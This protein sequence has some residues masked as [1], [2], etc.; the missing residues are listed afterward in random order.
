MKTTHRKLNQKKLTSSSHEVSV[1][2]WRFAIK[3]SF[4]K[5]ALPLSS[6]LCR[7][8]PPNFI[9]FL[10]V[11]CLPPGAPSVIRP[12]AIQLFLQPPYLSEVDKRR[13]YEFRGNWIGVRAEKFYGASFL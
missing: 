2:S 6:S 3:G 8:P 11:V 9:D 12:I 5:L 13:I 1:P 10:F 7:V 4:S